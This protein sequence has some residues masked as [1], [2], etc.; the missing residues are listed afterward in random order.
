MRMKEYKSIIAYIFW[1]I[2][3]TLV[4]I[5]VFQIL[6]VYCHMN[7]MVANTIAWFLAVMVAF[8]SNKVW[9]FGSH[10]TTVKAFWI[11]FIKFYF[12]RG[13][14]LIIDDAIMFIGESVIGIHDPTAQLILKIVDNMIV[15]VVN[16]IF[17]KWLIF[18]DGKNTKDER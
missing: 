9:V 13:L 7:Y 11:E 15:I 16:Y 18:T 14:T 2:V 10:Y 17:S 5:V 6:N 8:F 1:G 3:T 12:Y 4:N